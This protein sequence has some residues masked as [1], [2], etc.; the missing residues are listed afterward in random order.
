MRSIVGDIWFIEQSPKQSTIHIKQHIMNFNSSAD[1]REKTA[2]HRLN[3]SAFKGLAAPSPRRVA[4]R[5]RYGDCVCE[6]ER[7]VEDWLNKSEYPKCWRRVAK[8][9][10]EEEAALRRS[11]ATTGRRSGCFPWE[12]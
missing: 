10:F 5:Y 8:E 7:E 11:A 9:E 12:D 6:R 2:K 3:A 1:L 4:S